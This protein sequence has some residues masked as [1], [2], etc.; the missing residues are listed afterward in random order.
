MNP[1]T[2]ATITAPTIRYILLEPPDPLLRL[3]LLFAKIFLFLVRSEIVAHAARFS[4]KL[5]NV[6]V[7]SHT[8]NA[9]IHWATTTTAATRVVLHPT[10]LFSAR[11]WDG[12]IFIA[13]AAKARV[14]QGKL[15]SL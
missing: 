11:I 5:Q 3:L 9:V 10:R 13:S 4:E 1:A 6:H 2:N 12:I 15:G 8:A 14:C 7:A